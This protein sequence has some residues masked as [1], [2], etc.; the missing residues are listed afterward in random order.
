MLHLTDDWY[1]FADSFNFTLGRKTIYKE[2]KLKGK[3]YFIDKKYFTNFSALAKFVFELKLTEAM[4]KADVDTL[5]KL[6]VEVSRIEKEMKEVTNKLKTV[7]Q[8][9]QLEEE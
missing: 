9:K 3:T 7:K 2:G 8:L 6:L 5:Q 4:N 1:L